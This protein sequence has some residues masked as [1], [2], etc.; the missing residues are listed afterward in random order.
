MNTPVRRVK[1][2]DRPS[3]LPCSSIDISSSVSSRASFN[4]P[5]KSP[6]HKAKSNF[7][8]L[9]S[10]DLILAKMSR[11]EPQ[12]E[13]TASLEKTVKITISDIGRFLTPLLTLTWQEEERLRSRGKRWET[14]VTETRRVNLQYL[15]L[16]DLLFFSLNASVYH[17]L[18]LRERT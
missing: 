9:A 7:P 1:F 15:F 8:C 11:I 10:I 18:C 14:T 2:H 16:L 5:K 4:G 3:R 13:P 17:P 12:A 6:V